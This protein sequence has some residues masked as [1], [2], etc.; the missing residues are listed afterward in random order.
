MSIQ[1]LSDKIFDGSFSRESLLRLLKKY[2]VMK[3][4]E[5]KIEIKLTPLK[6]NESGK[7]VN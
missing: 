7:I 5:S 3:E 2:V 1:E 6:E 4:E